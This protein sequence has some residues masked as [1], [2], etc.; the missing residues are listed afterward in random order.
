M[1]RPGSMPAIRRRPSQTMVMTPVPSLS[2]ASRTGTPALGRR[3]TVRSAPRSLT[4]SRSGASAIEVVPD[5]PDRTYSL[6]RCWLSWSPGLAQRL[7]LRRSLLLLTGSPRTDGS[8]VL[9]LDPAGLGR[10]HDRERLTDRHRLGA[11]VHRDLADALLPG[12]GLVR[13]DG[14]LPEQ[15]GTQHPPWAVDAD[16]P[17]DLGVATLRADLA[18]ELGAP[19]SLALG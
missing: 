18:D 16:H 7:M 19:R 3:V 8:S 2:S 10:H 12:P 5:L 11:A 15:R 6:R 4:R 17:G 14:G 9:L 1:A 13:L